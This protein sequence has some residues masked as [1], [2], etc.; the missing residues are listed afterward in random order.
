L[1]F[2]PLLPVPVVNI[3]FS[4]GVLDL[5][6][7]VL[8]SQEANLQVSSCA[9]AAASSS[10][11]DHLDAGI[12]VNELVDSLEVFSHL[13][14]KGIVLLWSIQGDQE[15]GRG[16]GR[17]LG[18]MGHFDVLDGQRGV[19]IGD[20][21]GRRSFGRHLDDRRSLLDGGKCLPAH[22]SVYQHSVGQRRSWTRLSS[23][24]ALR[25]DS[26]APRYEGIRD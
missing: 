23:A 19:G 7:L 15:D 1:P 13:I 20:L 6:R 2:S 26:R 17:R 9:K 14:C 24:Q 12:Y 3:S 5:S 22:W 4:L 21:E 25:A 10:Q 11:D 18:D 8:G 16:R